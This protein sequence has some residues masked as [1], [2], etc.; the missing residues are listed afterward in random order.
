MKKK[1]ITALICSALLV[2]QSLSVGASTIITPESSNYEECYVEEMED[3]EVRENNAK[4]KP[5]I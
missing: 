3:K 4:E 5:T 1:V 2:V